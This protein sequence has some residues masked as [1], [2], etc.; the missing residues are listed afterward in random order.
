MTDQFVAEATAFCCEVVKF[1]ARPPEGFALPDPVLAAAVAVW[2]AIFVTV[3]TCWAAALTVLVTVFTASVT[4][5]EGGG[6]ACCV[7]V[8]VEPPQAPTT[9]ATKV[10]ATANPA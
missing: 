7:T 4:V 5:L 8:L 2:A 9:I 6:A 3:F 10:G 1:D